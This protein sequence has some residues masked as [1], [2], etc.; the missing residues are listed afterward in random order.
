MKLGLDCQ[1]CLRG[2]LVRLGL[3]WDL[4]CLYL[5]F[6]TCVYVCVCAER[7]WS[8]ER[9]DC[10]SGFKEGMISGSAWFTWALLTK[11]HTTGEIPTL[12]SPVSLMLCGSCL[13]CL[14]IT[15]GFFKETGG[16][17]IRV[18]DRRVTVPCV[19]RAATTEM[20]SI[21]RGHKPVGSGVGGRTQ[22]S[23]PRAQEFE[24]CRQRTGQ[25]ASNTSS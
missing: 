13:P 3:A 15:V 6:F 2:T 18:P 4:L 16:W 1:L 19:A 8:K 21:L 24:E 11:K 20:D 7:L 17:G 23:Q 9:N 22:R 14:V 25:L 10:A 5:A 12:L